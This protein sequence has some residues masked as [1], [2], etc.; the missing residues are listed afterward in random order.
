MFSV[1]IPTFNREKQILDAVN[2]AKNFFDG[3]KYEIII[4]DDFSSDQTVEILNNTFKELI[5]KEIIKIIKNSQN[6]GVNF[7]RAKGI[8]AANGPHVILLDSDDELIELHKD[9]FFNEINQYNSAPL[10]FFRCVNESGRL[11]GRNLKKTYKLSLREYVEKSSS[12][13]VL[14]VINKDIVDKVPYDFDLIG[15][16]GL[17]YTRVIDKY[18][19]AINSCYVMRLYNQD[20]DGRLSSWKN[21]VNRINDVAQFHVRMLSEFSHAMNVKKKLELLLKITIFKFIYL[22]RGLF[23]K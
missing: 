19:P 12:G 15:C 14:I 22:F 16:E 13:E 1:V 21:F 23:R 4:V 5:K 18:G 10:I 20:G 8:D 3:T 9:K 17:A 11:V 2:S 7:A 6:Q